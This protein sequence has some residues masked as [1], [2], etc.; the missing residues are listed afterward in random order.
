VV[1]GC[2]L[3][4][5]KL[6]HREGELR[7]KTWRRLRFSGLGEV[8]SGESLTRCAG[9]RYFEMLLGENYF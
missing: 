7:K 9:V 5:R 3:L 2:T 6:D 1:R 4:A 8:L